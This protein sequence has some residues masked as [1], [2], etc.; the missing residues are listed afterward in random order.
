MPAYHSLLQS[1]NTETRSKITAGAVMGAFILQYGIQMWAS[2]AHCMISTSQSTWQ[3]PPSTLCLSPTWSPLWSPWPQPW[4][5][6]LPSPYTVP[7]SLHCRSAAAWLSPLPC[8]PAPSPST[9]HC[10]PAASTRPC[11]FWLKSWLTKKQRNKLVKT[12]NGNRENRGLKLAHWN[13][14][15]A[16][17]VNKMDEIEQVTTCPPCFTEK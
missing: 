12:F 8:W 3:G 5:T 2:T 7:C 10:L 9:A 14:G 13:A 17:L 16:H 11:R 15:S 4:L 6:V 1:N